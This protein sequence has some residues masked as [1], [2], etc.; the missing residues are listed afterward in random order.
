MAGKQTR[1]GER[2]EERRAEGK[3][4]GIG[5]RVGTRK[6]LASVQRGRGGEKEAEGRM[7]RRGGELA[8]PN[9]KL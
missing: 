5:N 6:G 8:Y 4:L 3:R 7:Q 1:G 9:V 2:K